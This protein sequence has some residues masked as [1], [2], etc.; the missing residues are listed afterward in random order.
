MPERQS[1]PGGTT[2]EQDAEAAARGPAADTP[3]GRPAGPDEPTRPVARGD[4][5]TVGLP[6][7]ITPTPTGDRPAPAP[8][9]S[10]SSVASTGPV[11]D[12]RAAAGNPPAASLSNGGPSPVAPTSPANDQRAAAGNLPALSPIG[13]PFPVAS[14]GSANDQ[15]AAAGNP[16]ALSP[17]G[18]PFTV[19]STGSANDQ[20][21]AASNPPAASPSNGGPS[22]GPGV[23]R[24]TATGAASPG[25][26][27]QNSSR[28]LSLWQ[29]PF[30]QPVRAAFG[31]GGGLRP[32]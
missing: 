25:R 24:P 8:N 4:A 10:A 1:P 18:G 29:W 23:D 15:W 5:A 31:P 17:I 9:G 12:Q 19:A 22:A 21:A 13:G 28:S 7:A 26:A 14:T 30:R 11:N 27:R 2:A 6:R 20:R 16:P 32:H 3:T